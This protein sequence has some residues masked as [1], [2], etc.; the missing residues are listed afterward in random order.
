MVR[1]ALRRGGVGKSASS[2]PRPASESSRSRSLLYE[3]VGRSVC[4]AHSRTSGVSTACSL[5]SMFA[6]LPCVRPSSGSPGRAVDRSGVSLC[7]SPSC[8]FPSA[9]QPRLSSLRLPYPHS[10]RRPQ[11]TFPE[12]PVVNA[13]SVGRQVQPDRHSYRCCGVTYDPIGPSSTSRRPLWF[14]AGS[15]TTQNGRRTLFEARHSSLTVVV[16]RNSE[17]KDGF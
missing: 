11:S 2:P 15:T 7:V 1:L 4:D 5:L 12:L 8:P 10:D 17:K 14:P 6:S 13:C 16:Y 3:L 9:N